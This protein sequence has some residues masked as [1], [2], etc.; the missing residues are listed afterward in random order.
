MLDALMR[1]GREADTRASVFMS[2]A[3]PRSSQFCLTVSFLFQLLAIV[4]SVNRPFVGSRWT[5]MRV[6]L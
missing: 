2:D 1:S 3:M 6:R 4:A 5:G